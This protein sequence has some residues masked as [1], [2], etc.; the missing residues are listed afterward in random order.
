MADQSVRT[1]LFT[2]H[3]RKIALHLL[4][5]RNGTY[6]L[7]NLLSRRR[8]SMYSHTSVTITA[9]AEYHSM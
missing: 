7:R 4:A 5:G 9:K 6:R 3:S 8:I 1:G 2:P